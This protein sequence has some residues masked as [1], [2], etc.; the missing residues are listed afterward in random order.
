MKIKCLIIDDEPL[1]IRVIENHLKNFSDFEVIHTCNNPIEGFNLLVQE[2]V[3]LVFLDIN[4]PRVN[5]L[6]FIRNLSV[7]PLIIITTAYREYAVESFELDVID[8]LVKPISLER[9]MI[10]LKKVSRQMHLQK[11]AKKN[12]TK[13]TI[14]P[15][16][17][18]DHFFVKVNKKLIKIFFND[19]LYI[20][21]L[22]DYV[23]IKTISK[24]YITHYNLA[25]ITRL[26]PEDKFIRIH[27]SFTISLNKV[28]AIEGNCIHINGNIVP[29]GRNY[30]KEVK[31]KILK[32]SIT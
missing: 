18:Y 21:S 10:S 14:M 25:A 17:D 23:S 28:D 31:D 22:K 16:E 7:S 32:G 15:L 30:V 13:S 4:M 5:G 11:E 8:Y 12:S 29:I 1:A 2:S 3:D 20:E 19:I 24:D 6:D 26:I 9:F 27:R